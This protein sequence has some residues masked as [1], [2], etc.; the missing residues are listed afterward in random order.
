MDNKQHKAIEVL[1]DIAE[2][3][4]NSN[5]AVTT[6]YV[7]KCV[8]LAVTERVELLD[9]AMVKRDGLVRELRK[10]EKPDVETYNAD[11]SIATASYSK[12][13][14]STN[15]KTKADLEKLETAIDE[16]LGGHWSKLKDLCK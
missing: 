5:E 3:V 12:D 14:L 6:A 16:A 13:R 15:H 1:A 10:N 11:G 2:R 8:H 4:R 9:K 7:D